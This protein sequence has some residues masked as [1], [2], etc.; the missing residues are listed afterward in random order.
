L[1]CP[2]CRTENPPEAPACVACGADLVP[3]AATV[4][5]TA[6][7]PVE[8][9]VITVDLRPGAV[10]HSR[11]EIRGPLGRGGMGMVFKAHDR[12]LDETVAIKILRP[13]FAQDPKM[14]ERFRSEI[15]LARKVRHKN[16]CTIHDY[17][18]DH[19]L[20]YI[21]MEFVEGVDLKHI[22]R[23]SGP[24]SPETAFD[25]A[26]QVAEGLSAVHEA[27]IVHRDLKT[28]NIML[29]SQG[30]ARLMD[31]GVAK[32]LGD[33]S[34]T[35]TGHI[36]GTPEY[37]SPEQAQGKKADFRSDIYALG[38]VIYEIFT[39][40]VPFRGDTPLSTIL[41]HLND[42]PPL[43]GAPASRLPHALR[44]V[45][46][47]AL[48]K[49]PEERHG[50]ARELS[51]ALRQAHA[52]PERRAPPPRPEEPAERA[53]RTL[54]M[55]ARR[56]SRRRRVTPLRTFLLVAPL[57]AVG[58]GVLILQTRSPE[59]PSPQAARVPDAAFTPPPSAPPTVAAAPPVTTMAPSAAAVDAK[60]SRPPSFAAPA[61]SAP[62]IHR[63]KAAPTRGA[64]AAA[65]RPAPAPSSPA[66]TPAPVVTATTLP[67]QEPGLLQVVV[68]P[69]GT[70]WV[71]G[72]ALGETPLGRIDL[73]AGPHTLRV[74]HP[75]YEVWEKPITVR[76]GHVERIVV[77]LEKEGVKKKD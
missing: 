60:P 7:G 66:A 45:L 53:A 12:S 59:L 73:A 28:P 14:G 9:F 33:E 64:P 61:P 17:G 3:T 29:D 75:A 5:T 57:L 38:I 21:S 4:G 20:L 18:E 32:R 31:F 55:P 67:P 54:A 36:V 39:G 44:P 62:A 41:K 49:D 22:L 69:W 52:P 50:G 15:K 1:N 24:L 6:S 23:A 48:A 71:D 70:V 42:P 40:Q 10:F 43:D 72:R 25:V 35:A 16:V 51:E 68:K 46:R 58:G 26:I 77:D 76:P 74:R 65:P 2:S 19:G 30:M 13:E 63:E 8:S 37:M 56:A 34:L 11:Y 47:R 27:G